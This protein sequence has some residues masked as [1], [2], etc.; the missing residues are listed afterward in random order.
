MDAQRQEKLDGLLADLRSIPG[1]TSVE[2]DDFDS[3]YIWAFIGLQPDAD[4]RQ[5]Q[6][7]NWAK[8]IRSI[9]TAIQH[10][11]HKHRV[12]VTFLAQPVMEYESFNGRKI[13]KG[14]DR[15]DIKLDLWIPQTP[16]PAPQKPQWKQL[17]LGT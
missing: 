3:M 6:V 2:S 11:C 8:P 5:N 13:P 9:K 4:Y 14:Y 7:L 15:N 1:V 17:A 10:I 16:K 12:D